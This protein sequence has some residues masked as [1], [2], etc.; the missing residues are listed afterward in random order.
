MF[1]ADRTYPSHTSLDTL[2][3]G[4]LSNSNRDRAN[5]TST[6][7]TGQA[8]DT[9][10]NADGGRQSHNSHLS[11]HS[12]SQSQDNHSVDNHSQVIE[13]DRADSDM[14]MHTDSSNLG[15]KRRQTYAE[16]EHPL[17]GED[18]EDDA[19]EEE[20]AGEMAYLLAQVCILVLFLLLTSFALQEAPAQSRSH[21]QY[22][23]S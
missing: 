17:E 14:P 7:Q 11:Q 15:L 18:F 13:A 16:F 1:F 10:M 23:W 5:S 4:S 8:N 20:Y 9:D 3:E 2:E 12:Q 21:L 22:Q 19:G 6:T